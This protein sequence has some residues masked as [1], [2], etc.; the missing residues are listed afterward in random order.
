MGGSFGG[1]GYGASYGRARD[2]YSID[3]D[4]L[5]VPE[6][7]ALNR[8]KSKE[9]NTPK[10]RDNRDQAASDTGRNDPQDSR[11]KGLVRTR[12]SSSHD[13]LPDRA[14]KMLSKQKSV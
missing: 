12:A 7:P 1:A 6:K 5:K 2:P 13:D 10:R 8:Q 14:Q 3:I 4:S 9:D 11:D